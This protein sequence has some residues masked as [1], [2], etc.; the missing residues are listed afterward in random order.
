M[1]GRR[2]ARRRPRQSRESAKSLG[3]YVDGEAGFA[4]ALRAVEGQACCP[5][6]THVGGNL[7]AV[8]ARCVSAFDRRAGVH[9]HAIF[10]SRY[11]SLVMGEG[12]PLLGLVNYI[13]LNPVRAHRV[14]V[15][16]L[17]AYGC[18]SY[19]KFFRRKPPEPLR[20]GGFLSA[21]E[22]S[23]SVAGMGQWARQLE[24]AEE[25]D[26]AARDLLAKRY[27]TGWAVAS[28]E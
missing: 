10:E 12:R 11:K 6:T 22:F 16:E 7:H 8:S 23:D 3:F 24:F 21:L 20:R 2:A 1:P 9:D 14:D 5:V 27:C 15:A 17:R 13:H 26:P 18:S 28:E 19:P 4:V 25:S